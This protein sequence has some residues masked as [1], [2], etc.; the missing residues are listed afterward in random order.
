MRRAIAAVGLASVLTFGGATA[1]MAAPNS[2]VAQTDVSTD[3]DDGGD[4]GLWGL[5]GLLGLAGLAGLK[6]RDTNRNY[7]TRVE[8]T[9]GV[10]R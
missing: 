9:T 7:D 5:L 10:R 1:A 3:D 6:R 2:F 8:G 4:A